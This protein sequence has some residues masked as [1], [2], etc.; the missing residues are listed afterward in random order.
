MQDPKRSLPERLWSS[1]SYTVWQ[2]NRPFKPPTDVIEL[3]DRILVLVEIAGMRASQI[4][5]AISGRELVISGERERPQV[6]ATG[7]HQ[8]EV[9][10][11]EFRVDVTLPFIVDRSSVIA[12]YR[13]GFLQVELPRERESQEYRIEVITEEQDADER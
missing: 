7:Y 11:G 9:G 1:R 2:I 10:Y 4:A 5:V 3:P 12:T 8:M 6:N 13:D